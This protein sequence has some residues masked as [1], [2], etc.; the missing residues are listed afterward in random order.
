LTLDPARADVHGQDKKSRMF[1]VSRRA[2][3]ERAGTVPCIVQL[4]IEHGVDVTAQDSTLSPPLNLASSESEGSGKT[5]KLLLR[6]WADV[7]PQDGSHSTPLHLVASSRW[8]LKGNVVHLL[9]WCDLDA[10]DDG[11]RSP[12]QIASSSGLSEITEPLSN[13]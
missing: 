9:L 4:L 8:A 2:N 3:A 10:K 11:G 6:H 5:V 13:Y 12:F 1:P 7:N